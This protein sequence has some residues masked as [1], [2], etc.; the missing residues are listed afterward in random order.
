MGLVY[1]RKSTTGNVCP[2]FFSSYSSSNNWKAKKDALRGREKHI[3]HGQVRSAVQTSLGWKAFSLAYA[4]T[5]AFTLW[6]LM[7]S[8]QAEDEGFKKPSSFFQPQI[9]QCFPLGITQQKRKR[10]QVWSATNYSQW[11]CRKVLWFSTGNALKPSIAGSNRENPAP[12][13]DKGMCSQSLKSLGQAQFTCKV[14]LPLPWERT[15]GSYTD[16]TGNSQ[17]LRMQY[18]GSGIN[19]GSELTPGREQNA[20]VRFL[21][22]RGVNNHCTASPPASFAAE[23][24]FADLLSTLHS[25]N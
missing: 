16:S 22:R 20:N 15:K 21:S 7:F 8:P 4:H 12:S 1:L 17:D 18:N 13:A 19:P 11:I 14:K 2:D 9:S 6:I 24:S 3:I 25:K 5:P 10:R 23:N